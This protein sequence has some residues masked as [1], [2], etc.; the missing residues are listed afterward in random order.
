MNMNIQ[1]KM[2]PYNFRSLNR[3]DLMS[4]QTISSIDE[5][6]KKLAGIDTNRIS[7]TILINNDIEGEYNSL[8]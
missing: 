7:N 8:N 6:P 5:K 1:I 2:D 4:M 3:R